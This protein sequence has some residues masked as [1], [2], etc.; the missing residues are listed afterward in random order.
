M[1]KNASPRK[2]AFYAAAAISAIFLLIAILLKATG[3]INATVLPFLMLVLTCFFSAYFV[4]FL[5]ELEH[6]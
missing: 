5:L 4:F 1:F 6:K 3:L 2:L